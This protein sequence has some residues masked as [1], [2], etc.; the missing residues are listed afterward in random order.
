MFNEVG[1]LDLDLLVE[2]SVCCFGSS[3]IDVDHDIEY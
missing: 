2:V 1:E 3:F